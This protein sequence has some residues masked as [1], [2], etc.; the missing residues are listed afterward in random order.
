VKERKRDRGTE[1]R[2]D[3][4]GMRGGNGEGV[5]ERKRDRGTEGRRDRYGMR[6]G[7]GDGVKEGND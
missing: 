4:Y 6:G 1:G 3:R 5:K 7:N 2:R